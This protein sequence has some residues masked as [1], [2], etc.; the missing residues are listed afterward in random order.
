MSIIDQIRELLHDD[1]KDTI[2]PLLDQLN[3]CNRCHFHF[4]TC[5]K[6]EKSFCDQCVKRCDKCKQVYCKDHYTSYFDPSGYPD[7]ICDECVKI[8]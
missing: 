8:E 3:Q 5:N 4:I 6:C 1:Q 7:I 2:I